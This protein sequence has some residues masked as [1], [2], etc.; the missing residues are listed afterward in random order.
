MTPL[1]YMF[2]TSISVYLTF[3]ITIQKIIRIV[4]VVHNHYLLLRSKLV[5]HQ[6]ISIMPKNDFCPRRFLQHGHQLIRLRP[7]S[8][9]PRQL[10]MHA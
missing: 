10:T 5:T 3:R 6:N 1:L 4:I 2:N 7:S 8:M 9:I